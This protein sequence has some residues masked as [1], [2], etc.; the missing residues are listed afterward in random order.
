MNSAAEIGG[1]SSAQAPSKSSPQKQPVL[2]SIFI[3][4]RMSYKKEP[5]PTH[6]QIAAYHSIG[7]LVHIVGEFALQPV[8]LL[9]LAALYL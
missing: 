3:A 2:C 5:S 9:I 8:N 7:K 4:V 1:G 6:G